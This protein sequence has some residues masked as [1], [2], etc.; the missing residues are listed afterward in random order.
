MNEAYQTAAS[1]QA[2]IKGI[3]F[4]PRD[5]QSTFYVAVVGM[6]DV[7]QNEKWG[8]PIRIFFHRRSEESE[9]YVRRLLQA[10]ESVFQETQVHVSKKIQNRLK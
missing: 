3:S 9:T 2:L 1:L 5:E 4:S 8:T 6:A 10:M 7:A